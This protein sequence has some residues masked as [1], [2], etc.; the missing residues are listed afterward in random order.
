MQEYVYIYGYL[1]VMNRDLEN[2]SAIEKENSSSNLRERERE[3]EREIRA[4]VETVNIKFNRAG[5]LTPWSFK[6]N[7]R[8][9][10]VPSNQRRSTRVNERVSS[11]GRGLYGQLYTDR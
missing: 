4:T 11:R 1:R 3:R 9:A 8:A 7:H 10:A 5:N 2:L 6:F